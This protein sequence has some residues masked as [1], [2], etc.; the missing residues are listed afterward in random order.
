MD[1]IK[2]SINILI[3]ELNE[4][5]ENEYEIF[6]SFTSD[7]IR[8]KLRDSNNLVVSSL[9]EILNKLYKT[10][11]EEVYVKPLHV[12]DGS[13]I[14]VIK[15]IIE[16]NKVKFK[17][18]KLGRSLLGY[19][20][21]ALINHC[22]KISKILL[23]DLNGPLL[24]VGHG[25]KTAN[26]DQYDSLIERL[27]VNYKY[28]IFLGTL[29]GKESIDEVLIKLE[30]SRIKEITIVPLLIMPGKHLSNDIISGDNSWC[31]LLNEHGIKTICITKSLLENK[32][33]RNIIYDE[34]DELY[35]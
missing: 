8:R 20:D 25:S 5:L 9:D 3:N 13:E 1:G 19:K 18:I 14:K 31:N 24:F 26:H 2:K 28:K 4:K 15:E 11:Y 22:D 6:N 35:I 16:T 33:I 27:K 7:R 29:E 12:F 34:I 21:R 30:D 10:G 32:E 23:R 17:K